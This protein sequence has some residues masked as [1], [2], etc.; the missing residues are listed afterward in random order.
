[1]PYAKQREG[2]PRV[3]GAGGLT[4]KYPTTPRWSAVR[5]AQAL[6][7]VTTVFRAASIAATTPLQHEQQSKMDG[8]GEKQV[9]I[10]LST[11]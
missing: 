7:R 9:A 4:P 2:R 11:G 5:N 6:A 8:P 10:S 1:M 3:E